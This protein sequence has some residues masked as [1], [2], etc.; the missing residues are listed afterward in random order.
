MNPLMTPL[1]SLWK[2]LRWMR[3]SPRREIPERT[4]GIRKKSS[5]DPPQGG[6][7]LLHAYLIR[8]RTSTSLRMTSATSVSACREIDSDYLADAEIVGTDHW[9][10]RPAW[11]R[12]LSGIA[13]LTDSFL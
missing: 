12:S 6:F 3:P 5:R 10:K 13:R 7:L 8:S 11:Q 1:M 9:R 2:P 4:Q